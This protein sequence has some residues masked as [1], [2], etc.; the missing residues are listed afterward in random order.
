MFTT[1]LLTLPL[2]ALAAPIDP[3]STNTPVREP[4]GIDTQMVTTAH[5]HGPNTEFRSLTSLPGLCN[6]L[7]DF[8]TNTV[9]ARMP[10]V[11]VLYPTQNC[12]FPSKTAP[13]IV[14]NAT[15][16]L[17]DMQKWATPMPVAIM[18]YADV[19]LKL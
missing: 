3:I 16:P 1:L 14:M 10:G 9:Y 13:L 4:T 18:C 8:P 2:L 15:G 5:I 17:S 19:A 6:A 7:P 11:C 12:E